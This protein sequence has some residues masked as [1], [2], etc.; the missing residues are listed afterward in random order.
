MIL[1]FVCAY[2]LLNDRLNPTT[3]EWSGHVE[4]PYSGTISDVPSA[5]T[6]DDKI[7]VFHQNGTSGEL[8]FNSSSDGILWKGDTPLT[9]AV[10]TDGLGATVFQDKLF[11][12]YQGAGTQTQLLY[13]RSFSAGSLEWENLWVDPALEKIGFS[14]GYQGF[15]ELAA[16]AKAST[17]ADYGFVITA[18]KLP[19]LYSSYRDGTRLF[20]EYPSTHIEDAIF[21]VFDA[22]GS[23]DD[24][25]TDVHTTRKIPR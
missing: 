8:W 11:I 5:V 22:T 17:G 21:Q 7:Y 4:L 18:T 25:D 15:E 19:L 10:S 12:L 6:F 1:R 20:I 9:H 23:Y 24:D 14:S 3:G 13:N 16:E 2:C